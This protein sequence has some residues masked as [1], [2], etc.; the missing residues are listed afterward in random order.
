[1]EHQSSFLRALEIDDLHQDL[2]SKISSFFE[3]SIMETCLLNYETLNN[4]LDNIR[5]ELFLI[6][7]QICEIDNKLNPKALIKVTKPSIPSYG[8]NKNKISANGNNPNMNNS[9][10]T[11]FKRL[12]LNMNHKANTYNSKASNTVVTTKNKALSTNFNSDI[13][14]KSVISNVSKFKATR[15]STDFG[16]KNKSVIVK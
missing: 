11:K 8:F 10:N 12:S 6:K 15:I 13:S 2:Q 16:I 5:Q 4:D 14:N 9:E 7:E 1:M 3:K